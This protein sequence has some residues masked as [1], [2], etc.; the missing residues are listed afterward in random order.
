MGRILHFIGSMFICLLVVMVLGVKRMM[1]PW[2]TSLYSMQ[3]FHEINDHAPGK[4][5]S[6]ADNIILPAWF[7]HLEESFSYLRSFLTFALHILTAH[8]LWRHH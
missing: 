1:Q 6:C 5:T 2:L 4:L 3:C 7:D 8:N